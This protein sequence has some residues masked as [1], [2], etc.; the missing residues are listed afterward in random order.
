[1]LRLELRVGYMQSVSVPS[2]IGPLLHQ[3]GLNPD[4]L[5][6]VIGHQRPLPP[7]RWR[8][9]YHPLL[10]LYCF[11]M[12]NAERRIDRFDLPARRTLE[13]GYIVRLDH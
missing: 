9:P 6:Y 2:L 7:T 13:I 10:N 5:I 11:L 12:R 4:D 3:E 1:M 8:R